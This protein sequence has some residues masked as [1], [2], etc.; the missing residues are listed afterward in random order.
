[1]RV[2][3]AT[4]AAWVAAIA[5]IISVPVS[6]ASLGYA[7]WADRIKFREDLTLSVTPVLEDYP[8]QL[9]EVPG[10]QT[11]T[12]STYWNIMVANNSD[13]DISL[14]EYDLRENRIKEGDV[15]YPSLDQGLFTL[16]F[17]PLNLPVNMPAGNAMRFY[18]K[19]G[20]LMDS[21]A[22]SVSKK[23][24][25][26]GSVG[27]FRKLMEYLISQSFDIY[28]NLNRRA[29]FAMGSGRSQTFFV[30]FRTA[31][32]T[33][34]TTAFS[35]SFLIEPNAMYPNPLYPNPVGP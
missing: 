29:W 22:F 5:A 3:S 33:A 34:F 11:G 12:V 25:Q 23:P 14:V 4:R 26:A 35:S 19:V 20:L 16:T 18:L 13:R 7:I 2:D 24:W 32:R 21:K 6:V 30:T 15:K 27:S 31:R 9:I 10:T 8:I 1:M 17:S 28:G